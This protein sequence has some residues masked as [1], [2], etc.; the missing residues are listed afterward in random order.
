MGH[1]LQ[2][3]GSRREVS[4]RIAPTLAGGVLALEDDDGARACAPA[5]LLGRQHPLLRRRF[6]DEVGP[7]AP[8]PPPR[9]QFVESDLVPRHRRLHRMS[10]RL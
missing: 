7:L 9:V 8:E 1:T 4:R 6:G 3:R 5:R 10:A 2:P